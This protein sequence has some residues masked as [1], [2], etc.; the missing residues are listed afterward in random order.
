MNEIVPYRRQPKVGRMP[1]QQH[2]P[3]PTVDSVNNR[4]VVNVYPICVRH[5]FRQN[6]KFSGSQD[7]QQY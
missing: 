4:R 6:M 3:N 7:Q 1:C 5:Y 2:R